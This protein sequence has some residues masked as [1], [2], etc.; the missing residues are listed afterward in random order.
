VHRFDFERWLDDW[1]RAWEA[2]DPDAFVPLLTP[3]V[4]WRRDPFAEPLEGTAAVVETMAAGLS[5]VREIAYAWEFVAFADGRGVAHWEVT[6]S[7]DGAE[8]M[9]FDGVLVGDF[10]DQGRCHALRE[11]WNRSEP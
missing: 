7:P 11:W 2:R 5:G 9:L 4:V 3:D 6:I 10:D 1:G 8:P